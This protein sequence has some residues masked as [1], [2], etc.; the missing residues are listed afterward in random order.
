MIIIITR[1]RKKNVFAYGQ[2]TRQK[3]KIKYFQSKKLA[4]RILAPYNVMLQKIQIGSSQ[5]YVARSTSGMLGKFFLG[6]FCDV[7]KMAIIHL[8]ISQI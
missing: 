2:N 6:Q 5:C 8:K 3:R 4:K 7:A 1:T